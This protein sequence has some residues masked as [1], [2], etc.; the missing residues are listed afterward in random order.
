MSFFSALCFGEKSSAAECILDYTSMGGSQ[1][2]PPTL[3]SS[4]TPN[5]SST[6]CTHTGAAT[7]HPHFW[8]FFSSPRCCFS[9]GC[10]V[11][12]PYST[13]QTF[14]LHPMLQR[15]EAI[16][17]P[18]KLTPAQR[19]LSRFFHYLQAQKRKHAYKS[20]CSTAGSS[21]GARSLTQASRNEPLIVVQ[22]ET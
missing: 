13:A 2:F 1:S 17:P 12:P 10:A 14:T 3:T 9:P 5:S 8:G 15:K 18:K 4:Q 19:K 11:P 7:P 6:P 21:H 22:E 20:R 16:N